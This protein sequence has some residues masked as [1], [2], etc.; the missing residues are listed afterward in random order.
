MTTTALFVELLI[1]GVLTVGALL[2]IPF[3][4]WGLDWGSG[5]APPPVLAQVPAAF[6]A[7]PAVSG[8]YTIGVAFDRAFDLLTEKPLWGALSPV[9]PSRWRRES[10]M[11]VLRKAGR[12]A[13][14]VK[15]QKNAMG[16]D[17]DS[18][19]LSYV[20]LHRSRGLGFIYQYFRSRVRVTRALL[21]NS[22]IATGP[23]AAIAARESGPLAFWGALVVMF[24]LVA[25]ALLAWLELNHIYYVRMAQA[26]SVITGKVVEEV[27]DSPR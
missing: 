10:A 24:T 25:I 17:P 9:L 14:L 2:S 12:E 15:P 4:I 7:I 13:P 23:V 19:M 22:I 16:E 20:V 6:W 11:D 8:L 18:S 26:I 1:V 5:W 27:V 21:C 3:S